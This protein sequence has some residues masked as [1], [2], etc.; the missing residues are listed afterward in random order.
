MV[1][2]VLADVQAE[3]FVDDRQEVGQRTDEGER[4][5]SGVE[6]AAGR[7][8]KEGVFDSDQRHTSFIKLS[9]QEAVLA[10]NDSGSAR[11]CAVGAEK[12]ADKL[13]A[14]SWISNHVSPQ[15]CGSRRDGPLMRTVWQ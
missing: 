9:S 10:A 7:R 8:E 4:R 2:V 3:D 14:A 15:P 6:E 11:C 1:E 5:G 12:C 13:F